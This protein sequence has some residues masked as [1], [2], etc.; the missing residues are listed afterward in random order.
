MSIPF[1]EQSKQTTAGLSNRPFWEKSYPLGVS[2]ETP[3]GPPVAV[4]SFLE[5]AAERWPDAEAIDFYDYSIS[6]KELYQL[7]AKAAK[8]FQAIGVR[9][10]VNVGLHLLN[11][12]H[13]VICAFG[14]LMAGGCVVS[15]SPH[16]APRE[17]QE[18]LID[19]E[20]RVI[21][22]LDRASLYNHIAP[23]KGVGSLETVVVC[24]I[25]DFLPAEVTKKF[26][27]APVV[28][29]KLGA[30]REIDFSELIA[31]D[32][33][34]TVY[35]HQSLEEENA[36]IAYSGGTTGEPK[37][38]MLTHA[39]FSA[40]V[41]IYLLWTSKSYWP[42]V[43]KALVVLPL[44]HIF[45][46]ASI[47]M[48]V[49]ATGSVLVLHLGFDVNRVL[50]DID[51]K[52][53]TTFAG[54]P[55]MYSMLVNHSKIKEFNLSSLTDCNV[56]GAPLPDEVLY[57]FRELT[58]LTP[59]LSYGLTETTA[60]AALQITDG[61][62]RAGTSGLPLPHTL[63]EIVDLETGTRVLPVGE[64][65]EICC[66]GPHVMKGYWK[67]PEETAKAFY[68]GRFHTGDIGFLDSDGYLTIVDRKK[69]MIITGGYNVFPRNVEKVISEHP[70]VAEAM[71]V[72]IADPGLGQVLKVFL[73]MKPG[74]EPLKYN[75][76]RAFLTD[77]LA[78]YEIPAEME[79]RSAL[80]KTAVGKLS[81]KD[82]VGEDQAKQ[83]RA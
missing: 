61:E 52:K 73:E 77:K 74:C 19:V 49:V 29:R 76:L 65:G 33:L 26:L 24:S 83:S 48:L 31:N 44:C 55:T 34:Y 21:V 8:G 64:Q 30:G 6:Y 22:T 1:S 39:N 67:K 2:S 11:T 7:A 56:G 38:A 80:P 3:L 78:S 50:A 12:P 41:D 71:V 9:P 32:G 28:A 59:Q 10:G 62:P 66:S 17:L 16:S 36:A 4:E 72:G 58:G 20:A 51:R 14:V 40:I 57:R 70:S 68:G 42:E 82:L 60:L 23:L 35:S 46:F 81:K 18:Q 79:I 27:I 53:I 54:V 13:Y 25:E 63:I 5:K 47:M 43:C 37:G 45:G 15:F 69:D 75:Q